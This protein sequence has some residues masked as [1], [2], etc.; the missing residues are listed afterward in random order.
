[1][2]LK[3]PAIRVLATYSVQIRPVLFRNP[4]GM[5][6]IVNKLTRFRVFSVTFVS[7]IRK[8]E[9]SESGSCNNLHGVQYHIAS[10]PPRGVYVWQKKFWNITLN[11]KQ[12]NI[13]M[14]PPMAT[15]TSANTNIWIGLPSIHLCQCF[16]SATCIPFGG[17]SASS[18]AKEFT[19]F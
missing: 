19:L 2:W 12:R 14:I 9:L 18:L 4:T 1:M 16:S 3:C 10:I 8:V 11:R 5:G 15:A 17:A 6:V 13:S 7:W